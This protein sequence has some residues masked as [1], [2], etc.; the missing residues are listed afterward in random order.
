MT[1]YYR[2]MQNASDTAV[3]MAQSANGATVAISNMTMMSKAA[4]VAL[5]ALSIA[6]NM[7]LFA[8]I[9]KGISMAVTSI[10]DYIHRFEKAKET[11]EDSTS[12]LQSTTDEVKSLNDELQ[13]TQDRI[14][15]LQ[16]LAD[17]GTISVADEDE[18]NTLK[19]TNDELERQLALKQAT[20]LDKAKS[21]AD[22]AS[23]VLNTKIKQNLYAKDENGNLLTDEDFLGRTSNTNTKKLYVDEAVSTAINGYYNEVDSGESGELYENKLEDLQS[24]IDENIDAVLSL[25]E[26]YDA[27]IETGKKLSPEQQ[28]EYDRVEAVTEKYLAYSYA[29]NGTKES[30][31]A[32][33]DSQKKNVVQSKLSEQGLTDDQVDSVMDNMSEEDYDSFYDVSFDFK[34]PSSEDYQTASEYGKAYVDA[35]YAGANEEAQNN[36]VTIPS[37]SESLTAIQTLSTGLDQL[38]SIYADVYDKE[39]FDWS[40]I[41]NNEDFT[42]TFSTMGDSYD[43]FIQTVSN[44]P[45]DLDACQASFNRLTTAYLNNS[46]A[47]DSVTD[48]TKDSTIAMLKQM[49]I[50]NATEMVEA[51]LAA[52]KYALEQGCYDLSNATLA[53]YA[54]LLKESDAADISSQYIAQLALEKLN[55]NNI[56]ISTKSDIDNII[57]I[58]NAA[59]AS[60]TQISALTNAMSVLSNF[61]TKLHGT[62]FVG[63]LNDVNET[64]NALNVITQTFDKIKSGSYNLNAGDYYANYTGGSTTQ[65]AKDTSTSASD[66]SST[67]IETFDFIETLLNR[68]SSAFDKLKTKGENTFKSFTS[69]TKAYSSALKNINDQI[70]QQSNAYNAY[71]AKANTTGLSEEWASQVRNGSINIQDVDNDT[72]KQ[73]ISDYQT[74]YEKAKDCLDTIETLNQSQTELTQA[75]I[76]TLI[77]KYEKLGDAAESANSRINSSISLKESWGGSASIK[78]YTDMNKNIS[79]QIKYINAQNTQLKILQ[80]TV[81]K[82]SEEWYEYQSRIDDNKD[83]LY[84]LKQQM[85]ENATA[86]AALASATAQS[87]VDKYDASD[88]LLEAKA[89]NTTT[90]SSANKLIDSEIKNIANRQKAY[91]TAVNTDKSNLSSAKK[92]INNTKTTKA[93]KSV[94]KQV[95]AAIKAKKEISSSLLN[96]A[97]KLDDNGSLYN[98]CVKYNAYLEAY[99]TDK[100]TADLY[101]QTSQTDKADLAQEQFDNVQK[102]YENQLSSYAQSETVLNNQIALAEAQGKKVSAS[103]YNS[104]ITNEKANNT[105]LIA[106]RTALQNKLTALLAN[107]SITKGSDEYYSMLDA[108]NSVTNAIAESDLALVNYSNDLRQLKWD[109]FDDGIDKM[110]NL[111]TESDYYISL[112]E[113]QGNLVDD[114]GNFTDSGNATLSLRV[115]NYKEYMSEYQSYANEIARIKKEEDLSD[116]NVIARLQELTEAQQQA[117]LSAED[118]KQAMIDLATEGYDAQKSSLQD[119]IDTYKDLLSTKSDMYDYQNSIADK[120]KTITDLQK[121]LQAYSGDM[122]EENKATV[123]KLT[124][125]LADAQ[126]DLQETETEKQTSEIT[127]LLDGLYDDYSD[128]LDDKLDQTN[129]LI[130]TLIA[131]VASGTNTNLVSLIDSLPTELSGNLKSLLTG[132]LNGSTTVSATT[133]A[134]GS[135]NISS[136]LNVIRDDKQ[137]LWYSKADGSIMATMGDGDKVFSNPQVENLW[138]LSQLSPSSLMSGLTTSSTPIVTSTSGGNSVAINLGGMVVNEASDANAIVNTM[139]NALATN[140]KL[141]KITQEITVGKLSSN[142]NSL[143]A[144]S[145]I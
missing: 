25:K 77:T 131:E 11:L 100:A 137:E 73:Q 10:D 115:A 52:N 7:I 31:D 122:S 14:A 140:S 2:T 120:T 28:E 50:S 32:L 145:Y 136:G 58:A 116:E 89:K 42:N 13:T 29:I 90:A 62:S 65:S 71:M 1:A 68:L 59:G 44:S 80:K 30:Y 54:S 39:D 123:Q 3:N 142:S 108:I 141:Q 12:S 21:D 118:E 43:E 92:S 63:D 125:D 49:G 45:N 22:D 69:R 104:L 83:S 8:V 135:N 114:S 40:S 41:L 130:E 17:D 9:A 95:K 56:Q 101:K 126:K 110:K 109:A 84:D 133:N 37:F 38:D 119:L 105:K 124:V 98:K 138:S 16:K 86:A 72:L 106:E 117:V 91:D 99:E 36:T 53:E 87:K 60:V 93:N 66:T 19:E 144:R 127:D 107:K 33:T 139:A 34:E 64:Q 85:S 129:I 143:K 97:A 57:A 94:L 46:T 75:K 61:T 4:A 132:I 23:K 111:L 24:Y 51:R 82:G 47:L 96:A 81:T 78:N 18:L 103:Y 67:T 15:E 55:L 121:Q 35:M 88:D 128:F 112:M 6:G 70:A 26:A 48:A 76:E 20:Q 79:T 5:K 102:Q 74:W 27:I 113:K 134:T